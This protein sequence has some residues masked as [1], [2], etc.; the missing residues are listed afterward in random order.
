MEAQKAIDEKANLPL[1]L[2]VLS[3]AVIDLKGHE[4]EG[5]RGPFP[6]PKPEKASLESL[7]IP[8]S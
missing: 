3:K 6:Q 4:T 1:V 8:P 2:T 7:E 5:K